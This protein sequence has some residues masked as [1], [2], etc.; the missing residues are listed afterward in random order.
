MISDRARII[1]CKQSTTMYHVISVYNNMVYHMYRL[2]AMDVSMERITVAIFRKSG[3]DTEI[4][5]KQECVNEVTDWGGPVFECSCFTN[6]SRLSLA[7]AEIK[8]TKP[9][10]IAQIS[11]RFTQDVEYNNPI[12]N[13][14]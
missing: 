5:V 13:P 12:C 8:I 9:K 3:R 11:N 4:R 14:L 7:K 2:S 6:C 10:E 1:T